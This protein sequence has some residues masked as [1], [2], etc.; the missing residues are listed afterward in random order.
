MFSSS[1][2]SAANITENFPLAKNWAMLDSFFDTIVLGDLSISLAG[3][4]AQHTNGFQVSGSA[5]SALNDSTRV[6]AYFELLE[7]V[8]IAESLG[9]E[10]LTSCGSASWQLSKS[11][12]VACS[13]DYE[14]ASQSAKFEVFER[15]VLLNSWYYQNRP[16]DVSEQFVEPSEFLRSNYRLG[17]FQF[18]NCNYN[19]QAHVLGYFGFPMDQKNP[20][21]MGFG[22][23][24]DFEVAKVKSRNE[25]LQRLG[26]L[27]GQEL[28]QNE[29]EF[30]PSAQ[31][32]LDRYLIPANWQLLSEWLWKAEG[33]DISRRQLV[34]KDAGPH[35][36]IEDLTP[37]DLVGKIWV[38]KASSPRF[39]PLCFGKFHPDFV[40][41]DVGLRVH[42]FA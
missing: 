14:S 29:P 1:P 11:N 35:W 42:P 10:R 22:C 34:P 38:L 19:S 36:I 3:F 23:H 2:E 12:G 26:F 27:W 6:R 13:L 18:A 16:V 4:T 9:E 24:P 17:M 30:S 21:I 32:H 39:T 15:H 7:R 20:L 40:G 33:R 41:G 5:A 31:Y 28:P 37:K 25:L 8:A